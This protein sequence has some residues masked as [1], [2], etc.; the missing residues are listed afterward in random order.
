MFS[1]WAPYVPVAE[2][3]RQAAAEMAQAGEA[4]PRHR[5]GR[6]PGPHHRHHAVGQ[7]VVRRDRRPQRLRQPPAARPHL[8]A[9]WLGGRSP[10][11]AGEDRRA[12]QRLR[13]LPHHHQRGR[14]G[15]GDVEAAVRRLRRRHRFAGGTPARALR[16]RRHDAAVPPRRRAVPAAGRVPLRLLLPGRRPHVQ[17]RRRRALRR[18]RAAG[19][20]ARTALHAAPGGSG[21][22]AAACQHRRGG[23][24]QRRTHAGDR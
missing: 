21:R 12:C 11:H 6:H 7:G 23:G 17:A 1:Q 18:R 2:R 15:R 8:C 20:A 13:D 14:L 3:R 9:Q 22:T 4:G 19:S 16:R 10:D 24:R 5:P